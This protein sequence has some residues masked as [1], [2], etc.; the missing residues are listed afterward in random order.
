MSIGN[1]LTFRRGRWHSACLRVS[2]VAFA[3][4]QRGETEGGKL[5]LQRPNVP[6]AQA[7]VVSVKQTGVASSKTFRMLAS[8]VGQPGRVEPAALMPKPL[9]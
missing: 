4:T 9:C 8:G 7:Q 5:E 1:C 3:P 2:P 6:L